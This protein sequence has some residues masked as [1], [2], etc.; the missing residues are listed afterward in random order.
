VQP[1]IRSDLQARGHSAD[2]YLVAL[3]ETSGTVSGETAED[4][5]DWL[6]DLTGCPPVTHTVLACCD[7]HGP[8]DDATWCY[9]EADASAGV[10]RRRCVACGATAALLDSAERWTFPP[11]FSCRSCSQSLVE[12]GAALSTSEADETR[13]V[14]LAAR[15]VGCGRI[16]GL[17]DAVV[18]GIPR[19]EILTRL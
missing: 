13:W 15:C 19:E 7:R 17:T 11:M 9:V 2:P 18:D 10:A 5:L 4:L 6:R 16:E 1:L 14:A 8:D 12:V 3:R